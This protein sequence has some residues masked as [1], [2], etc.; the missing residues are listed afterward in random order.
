M[1][2]PKK[3]A[4]VE[5]RLVSITYDA[6]ALV[7]LQNVSDVYG[8]PLNALVRVCCEVATP[9]V[10]EMFAKLCKTSL[11][12]QE[13]LRTLPLDHDAQATVMTLLTTVGKKIEAANN[14]TDTSIRQSKREA[15]LKRIDPD[16][17]HE[18]Q[19]EADDPFPA[20]AVS[21]A[22]FFK[23]LN[24]IEPTDP[25]EELKRVDDIT[26]ADLFLKL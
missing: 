12:Y 5:T 26:D 18:Y 8:I 11:H 15:L 7:P 16:N 23:R 1:G 21:E 20:P 9:V 19:P 25:I 24:L 13:V 17:I 10:C 14:S 3:P 4:D 2:R 6:A 22:D